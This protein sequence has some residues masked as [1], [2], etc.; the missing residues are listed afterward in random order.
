MKSK[1][2]AEK[3]DQYPELKASV[4]KLLLIVEGADGGV[5]SADDAEEQVLSAGREACWNTMQ[6]WATRQ[7]QQAAQ[8]LQETSKN[9]I[10]HGKKN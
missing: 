8:R 2:L 3:L 4:E 10:K 6:H 5:R 9:I 1:E 7:E